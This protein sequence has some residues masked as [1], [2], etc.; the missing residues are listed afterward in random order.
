MPARENDLANAI[1]KCCPPGETLKVILP[2]VN[3]SGTSE[4]DRL[5]T[6]GGEDYG[7][8]LQAEGGDHNWGWVLV[9][10]SILVREAL[11]DA[12]LMDASLPQ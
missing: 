11:E 12:R 4:V 1:D 10:E 5:F 7:R 8:R 6:A 2:E 9:D 3:A